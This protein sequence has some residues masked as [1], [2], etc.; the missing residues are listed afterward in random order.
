MAKKTIISCTVLLLSL[1][2]LFTDMASEMLYPIMPL[3]LKEIGFSIIAIGILEGFAEAVAG[4]SKGYFGTWSDNIGKRM[5]FVQW[6]YSVSAISKP[7]MAFF[8]YPWWIFFART[9]D[10]I[11]KGLR[12]GAR[13]AVLAEEATAETKGRVFGFHRAM[14]TA[15]AMIGPSIALLFL[16]FYPSQYRPLFLW[17]FIPG[18]AAIVVTIIIKE[19]KVTA[20]TTKKFPSFKSFYQYYTNAPALYKKLVS[21]LLLFTLFNSSDVFLLLKMKSAG[22]SDIALIAIYIFYNAV[23][24]LLSYPFGALADKFGLKNIFIAGLILFAIVYAGM[25][26]NTSLYFFIALF[27]VYGMYAA[28]TE[29]ISKAWISRIVNNINTASAIGTY[30]GFQSIASMLA[31]AIAGILWY[32]FG[33][34]FTFLSSAFVTLLVIIFIQFKI[35]DS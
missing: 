10:R 26:M 30:T 14:D 34:S 15:G 2:S 35:K 29:G 5:P 8:I 22:L 16:Y 11:G 33:P 27:F 13:D 1:V 12:T 32:E 18:V 6:G 23:Y 21:A 3:Y 19:K 20:K 17:A 7:M 31:S 28:A 24:A 25:S 4:L 9:I